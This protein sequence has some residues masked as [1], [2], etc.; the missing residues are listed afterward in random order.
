MGGHRTWTCRAPDE[1]N[2]ECGAVIYAPQH[3]R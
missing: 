2:R 1:N 3:V